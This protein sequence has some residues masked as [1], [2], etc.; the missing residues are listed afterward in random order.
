MSP[1]VTQPT[2]SQPQRPWR[3]A[4]TPPRRSERIV[5]RP[6]VAPIVRELP[7]WRDAR[8]AGGW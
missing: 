7:R 3:A 2:S 8:A 6:L 5:V 4:A 1:T